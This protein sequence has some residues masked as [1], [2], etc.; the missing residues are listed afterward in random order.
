[1]NKKEDEIPSLFTA[2]R[3]RNL[4]RSIGMSDQEVNEF[5]VKLEVASTDEHRE[6]LRFLGLDD[7][8]TEKIIRLSRKNIKD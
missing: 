3:F 2:K 7:E 1:M 5:H 6:F 8:M 4:L